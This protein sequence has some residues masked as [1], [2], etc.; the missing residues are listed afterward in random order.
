[1]TSTP[2]QPVG[3]E[4]RFMRPATP[5]QSDMISNGLGHLVMVEG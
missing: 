3:H 1:M 5:S 4:P 2:G